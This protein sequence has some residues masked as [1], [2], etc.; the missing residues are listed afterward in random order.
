MTE[1]F[2]AF[3]CLVRHAA[4]GGDELVK[5]SESIPVEAWA[6]HTDD[7]RVYDLA[8]R[9]AS[10][11]ESVNIPFHPGLADG[12]GLFDSDGVM[13]AMVPFDG[14]PRLVTHPGIALMIHV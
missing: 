4:V 2:P 3:V 10:S 1:S 6:R 14:G 13:L 9:G 8:P 7:S 12:V 5:V 11:P